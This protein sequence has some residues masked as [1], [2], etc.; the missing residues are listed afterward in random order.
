MH[1]ML[2]F[3]TRSIGE[4]TAGLFEAAKRLALVDVAL[5]RRTFPD[6]IGMALNADRFASP[7]A[8]LTDGGFERRPP[9][10]D[11]SRAAKLTSCSTASWRSLTEGTRQASRSSRGTHGGH[12]PHVYFEQLQWVDMAATA[13]SYLWDHDGWMELSDRS[14]LS[15]EMWANPP[16]LPVVLGARAQRWPL[17]ANSPRRHPLWK[18][19]RW[20]VR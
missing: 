10:P 3:T 8:D 1:A 2:G 17:P 16:R 12:G 4:A 13:A 19:R 9:W 6:T 14:P 15:P 11:G 20:R 5:A 18:R 7:D